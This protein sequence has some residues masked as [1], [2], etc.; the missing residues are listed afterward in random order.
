MNLRGLTYD[1]GRAAIRAAIR[2]NVGAFIFEIA[3]SEIGYTEQRPAEYATVIIAAAIKKASVARYLS[4]AT[5]SRSIG[6]GG[7]GR[8]G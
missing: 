3:R 5:T 1:V 7:E 8:C 4:R 6:K 2:H